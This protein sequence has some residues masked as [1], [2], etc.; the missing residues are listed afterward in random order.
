MPLAISSRYAQRVCA[1]ACTYGPKRGRQE[2]LRTPTEFHRAQRAR[3]AGNATS[4]NAAAVCTQAAP[5]RGVYAATSISHKAALVRRAILDKAG[6]HHLAVARGPEHEAH[7]VQ[8]FR[9][10]HRRFG[11]QHGALHACSIGSRLAAAL[12][13]I[14]PRLR[15]AHLSQLWP[16]WPVST[17]SA[18]DGGGDVGAGTSRLCCAL[19]ASRLRWHPCMSFHLR[20]STSRA[21]AC[22]WFSSR[23]HEPSLKE[24]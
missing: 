13:E 10:L 4:V 20:V 5:C 16:L 23:L 17:A 14:A 24:R 2:E 12:R 1:R 19:P 7:P 15:I 22:P 21:H 11:Q 3:A 6:H 18:Q 9:L 8:I